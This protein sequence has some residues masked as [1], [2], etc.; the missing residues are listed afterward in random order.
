VFLNPETATEDA[1]IEFP[2]GLCDLPETYTETLAPNAS[3]SLC[4][5]NDKEN[6]TILQGNPIIY[7]ESCECPVE[8][9]DPD[10]EAFILAAGIEDPTQQEAI[11]NLVIDLK[12]IGVWTKMSYIYPFVGGTSTTHSY[13]LKTAAID[14]TFMGGITHNSNGITYNGTNGYMISP[15]Q[16]TVANQ[17]NRSY[18]QYIRIITSGGWQGAFDGARVFGYQINASPSLVGT[19]LN[20]LNAYSLSISLGLLGATVTASNNAK[21]YNNSG[22]VVAITTPQAFPNSNLN[23]YSGSMNSSGSP[24]FYGNYNIAF[25]CQG[26][27]L[28]DTEAADLYSAVQN[29]NTI[30][31]RQVI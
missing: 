31:G 3:I 15:F 16:V 21:I 26:E 8:P 12:D 25:E 14:V 10:A 1:I 23:M 20:N 19:G 29:F 4:I 6:Y 22:I 30:L 27:G 18:F 2:L 7:M 5:P 28:N 13:N 17:Y 11:N 9:I 24:A